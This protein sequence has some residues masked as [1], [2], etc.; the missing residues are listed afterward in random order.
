MDSGATPVGLPPTLVAAGILPGMA[1][2]AVEINSRLGE[3]SE[4]GGQIR[5]VTAVSCKL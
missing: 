4:L 2:D 5:M 1:L 3:M